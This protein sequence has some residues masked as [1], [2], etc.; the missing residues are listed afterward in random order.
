[1]IE[2]KNLEWL[3]MHFDKIL[4]GNNY[5]TDSEKVSFC[6]S[7]AVLET[8]RKNQGNT[9][10]LKNEDQSKLKMHSEIKLTLFMN[11]IYFGFGDKSYAS[12]LPF[13]QY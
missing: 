11:Q 3:K 8:G 10:T 6:V 1:M 7:M 13:F 2:R 5:W 4:S 12:F 9:A